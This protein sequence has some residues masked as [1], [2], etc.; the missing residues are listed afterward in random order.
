M[1][2]CGTMEGVSSRQSS[3]LLCSDAYPAHDS[4]AA[5]C[6]QNISGADLRRFIC[7]AFFIWIC[8]LLYKNLNILSAPW[9]MHQ[10][11]A[12][13]RQRNH[14]EEQNIIYTKLE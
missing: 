10:D 5:A 11:H 8:R 12:A 2:G 7:S 6:R 14:S 1:C 13:A 9:Y 3:F 4:D